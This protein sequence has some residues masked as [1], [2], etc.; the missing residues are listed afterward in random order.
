MRDAD[1]IAL[2]EQHPRVAVVNRDVKGMKSQCFTVSHRAAGRLAA[3]AL[4]QQGH[5][6]IAVLAG[7]SAAGDNRLRLQGFFEQLEQGGIKQA[8]VLIEEGDFSAQ[9]GW[10]AARRLLARKGVDRV[11]ALFCANDQMAMGALS[12]LHHAG[13]DIPGDWSVVGYDDAEFAAY[14]SPRL[15]SVRIPIVDMALN[16]CRSLLNAC[17]ETELPVSQRF[18]PL[19]IA[20]ESVAQAA[21][22]RR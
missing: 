16:A 3:Q 11:T 20:R 4:Q 9:S 5:R 10:D 19:L 2:R 14:L 18:E 12:H 22:A 15:T 6:H 13:I 17:Y 21:P 1:F 7:P 8:A